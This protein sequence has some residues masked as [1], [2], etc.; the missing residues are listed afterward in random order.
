MKLLLPFIFLL[1]FTA[2][3]FAQDDLGVKTYPT[4]TRAGEIILISS[5]IQSVGKNSFKIF[6][7]QSERTAAYELKAV[8]ALLSNTPMEVLL[9]N[10]S[11]GTIIR[12]V[13][14]GWQ[15]LSA[16]TNG[17]MQ[18]I[19][20]PA[21]IHEISFS[22]K[23]EMIPMVDDIFFQSQPGLSEF[24]SK[25]EAVQNRINKAVS[26]PVNPT[27]A[28]KGKEM[29]SNLVL[30][31]PLGIYDHEV[32]VAFAY[33]TFSWVYLTAG[34]TVTFA[35]NGSTADP[36]LHLFLQNNMAYS[37]SNDDFGGTIES[38]ITANITVTGYYA[39]N[40]RPYWNAA[41]GTTNIKKNGVD[42]L[43]N[44]PIGGLRFNN[45]ARTGDLNFFTCRLTT[46]DTRMFVNNYGGTPYLGYNDDYS[47]LGDWAWGV[48]SRI[49]MNFPTVVSNSFVC[50]YSIMS[51]GICDVYMGNPN[52]EVNLINNPEFPILKV[53]DAIKTAPL[54]GQYNCTSWAGGVTS[55]FIWPPSWSSTY[56]CSGSSQNLDCFDNFYSNTPASRYPGAWNYSRS[57]ATSLNNAIDLWK[58]NSTFTHASVRK[59]G[60]NNPHGYDWESKPGSTA[61]TLHPR[62]A[63]TGPGYGSV[64]NYYKFTGTYAS[65]VPGFAE[66]FSSD[67][68]AVN[69]GVAVY[70]NAKLT[71]KAQNKLQQLIG[72]IDK[73]GTDRFNELYT[74]WKK[75]WE[76][77]SIYSDPDMYCRNAEFEALEQFCKSNYR[78]VFLVFDKYVNGDIFIGKIVWDMTKAKYSKLLEEAKSDILNN[79]SDEQG[80]Y[81]IHG[82][83][84]NGIR[85]IEKI[86]NS[87]DQSPVDVRIADDIKVIVSPN[88]V[89]DI[90]SV[91]VNTS[92]THRISIQL[93]ALNSNKTM[94]LQT[95]KDF[96]PGQYRFTTNIASLGLNN[97]EL[98]AVKV[99]TDNIERTIK[100]FVFK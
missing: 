79:P 87:I 55:A 20:I 73:S 61:R 12:P 40:A 53:D 22:M 48:C 92:S 62:N 23:G 37:W 99:L 54:T 27:P 76:T 83:L 77:N 49:K 5:R 98:L 95:E 31:N 68:D 8:T 89:K 67:A 90:I 9:D 32:D 2:P 78:N 26:Q 39:L 50:A 45:T 71:A 52:S 1:N 69:A 72:T 97:G 28:A 58:L 13:V 59:P 47:T 96:A 82:D 6:T 4:G 36:V 30:P 10:R 65:L 44:T 84:D 70:E 57:G 33:S 21:G 63:L 60:N 88:P 81:K 91:Q 51:T 34:T 94:V 29:E 7:I 66:G 86:L 100:A 80:R 46:G 56:N 74:A 3:C 41:T 35:T 85:Y 16:E 25:W 15:N 43:T 14:N 42:F 18:L 75:T 17:K 19:N 38:S 93:L 11:T 64:S 24:D